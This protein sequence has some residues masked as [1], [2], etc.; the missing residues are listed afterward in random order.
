[1]SAALDTA[2]LA[3]HAAGDRA[4]LIALYADAA[5]LTGGVAAAF[6]LTHAYVFALEAGDARSPSLRAR[7]VEMGAE[8]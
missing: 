2:L 4:E 6:Y 5:D 3:A 8:T 1:M 7:L